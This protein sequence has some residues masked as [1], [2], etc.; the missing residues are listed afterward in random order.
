MFNSLQLL[1]KIFQRLFIKFWI[2]SIFAFEIDKHCSFLSVGFLG[3]DF[4]MSCHVT[5]LFNIECKIIYG[6]SYN[7]I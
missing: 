5:N 6:F 7:C 2:I 4:V 1:Y 3:Q